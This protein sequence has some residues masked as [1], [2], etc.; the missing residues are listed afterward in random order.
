MIVAV[1]VIVAM[2][3]GFMALHALSSSAEA[4]NK[5]YVNNVPSVN[6]LGQV[7]TSM[8]SAPRRRENRFSLLRSRWKRRLST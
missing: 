4:A 6:A 3:I 2:L 8:V 5:L 7:G 1:G